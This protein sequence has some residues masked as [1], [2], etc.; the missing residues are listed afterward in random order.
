MLFIEFKRPGPGVHMTAAQEDEAAR[1]QRQ[2][3]WVYCVAGVEVGKALIDV[4]T[5]HKMWGDHVPALVLAQAPRVLED[6]DL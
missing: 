5:T 1:L 4:W 3:L 2:N 6:E